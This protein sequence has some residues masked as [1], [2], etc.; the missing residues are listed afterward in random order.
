MPHIPSVPIE[1]RPKLSDVRPGRTLSLSGKPVE[2][3]SEFSSVREPDGHLAFRVDV[4][5]LAT[6]E[7]RP[8]VLVIDLRL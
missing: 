1:T 3:V 4:R 8:R 6:G 2:V 7:F 5:V